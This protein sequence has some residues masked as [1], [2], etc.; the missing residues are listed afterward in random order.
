MLEDGLDH[1]VRITVKAQGSN[2]SQQ[3]FNQIPGRTASATKLLRQSSCLGSFYW[4]MG[5]LNPLSNCFNVGVFTQPQIT[6]KNPGTG[7]EP[8]P[9]S[10]HQTTQDATG[11]SILCST[12][13]IMPQLLCHKVTGGCWQVRDHLLHL[14][15]GVFSIHGGPKHAK[16]R[17]TKLRN[18]QT[19][20]QSGTP[21]VC[22]HVE[23]TS[24]SH[25]TVTD[26]AN[27]CFLVVPPPLVVM[28]WV[29]APHSCH[30]GAL[31]TPTHSPEFKWA[32]KKQY[33][34][35]DPGGLMT[36]SL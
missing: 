28:N 10:L 19:F 20:Y 9:K 32:K 22:C 11:L 18:I 5:P 33:S 7:D 29:Q 21:S 1:M 30:V 31:T 17:S 23:P 24:P 13:G 2:F 15:T 34:D 27:G 36:G 35:S 12:H 6:R 4:G 14:R 8:T 16:H 3:L 25:F 26:I